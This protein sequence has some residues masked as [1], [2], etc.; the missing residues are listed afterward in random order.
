MN[1][2]YTEDDTGVENM[3]I[4]FQ[5]PVAVVGSLGR[6]ISNEISG[7][8]QALNSTDDFTKAC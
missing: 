1:R 2:G 4:P 5:P 3:A 8:P 6:Q 7:R